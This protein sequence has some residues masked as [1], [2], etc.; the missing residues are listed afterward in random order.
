MLVNYTQ[1]HEEIAIPFDL[2]PGANPTKLFFF[3]NKE[4]FRFPLIG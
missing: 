3:A 4:F 1:R 2:K